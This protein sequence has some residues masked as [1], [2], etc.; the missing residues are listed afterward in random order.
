LLP[1]LRPLRLDLH[2]STQAGVGMG[3]TGVLCIVPCTRMLRYPVDVCLCIRVCMCVD[4]GVVSVGISVFE[5]VCECMGGRSYDTFCS[6]V[7][8]LL[9]LQGPGPWRACT[10]LDRADSG[11]CW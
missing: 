5:C 10:W 3:S 11:S 4:R 6:A 1:P 2:G 7:H 8:S 9:L